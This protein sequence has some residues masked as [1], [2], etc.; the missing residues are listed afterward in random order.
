[1]DAVNMFIVTSYAYNY[2][3]GC[4]TT[5]IRKRPDSLPFREVGKY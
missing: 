5:V 1:M 3:N 4:T 2:F